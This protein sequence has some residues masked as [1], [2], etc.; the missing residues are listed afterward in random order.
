MKVAI[1]DPSGFTPP[2][3][4]HLCGALQRS[5]VEVR[6]YTSPAYPY[7]ND[8][9]EYQIVRTFY[10]ISDGYFDGDGRVK[11][12]VKGIEHFVDMALFTIDLSRWEP[13]IIHF[14]WLPLPI[15]D[16][17]FLRVLKRIAPVVHTVHDTTPFHDASTSHLQLWRAKAVRQR[18]DWLITH[19]ERGR[20]TL[21]SD[22][23]NENCISVVP[24][25]VIRYEG[26]SSLAETAC[27]RP[28]AE[29]RVLLFGTL[30]PYKGIDVL[31]RAFA[32]L[33]SS[34]R[35][36]TELYIAGRAKM[37]ISQLK[38]LAERLGIDSRVVWDIRFVPDAEI[39]ALIQSADIV[40]LPYRDIDQSG[41]LMTILPYAVPIVATHIGGFAETLTDGR[42]GRLVPP[43]DPV[44]FSEA[45][46]T[47]LC[48]PNERERMEE[49]LRQL[50]TETHAWGTIAMR[51]VKLYRHLTA[52]EEHGIEREDET[53]EVTESQT[54]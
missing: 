49:Q 41:V 33:P 35:E 25:G 6:L 4:H 5:D 29:N 46:E 30:K 9:T 20:A 39:P 47:L 18:F 51:T 14:Q 38:S 53:T 24:H 1:L 21:K 43:D 50:A 23:V 15:V 52:S 27:R 8:S 44:A 48:R 31:L 3:D 36:R 10:H 22:G 2:Y 54:K 12:G 32:S 37:D 19:T 28:F 11:T 45:L 7:D 26:E 17:Q 42:H 40:A 16:E 34:V 13:D